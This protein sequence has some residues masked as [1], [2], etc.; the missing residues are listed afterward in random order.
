MVRCVLGRHGHTLSLRFRLGKKEIGTTVVIGNFRA[1][2]FKGLKSV[3]SVCEIRSKC[4][5][6]PEQTDFRQVYYFIGRTEKGQE[7]YRKKIKD[8]IDSDHGRSIYSKRIG[9][10]EP[11]FANLRHALGL[12]RFTLRGK[13]K[14]NNQ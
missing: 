7:T 4:L 12:N 2:R 9:T 3:C 8:K 11:V 10:A 1:I 13:K 14:V 6:H 5:K